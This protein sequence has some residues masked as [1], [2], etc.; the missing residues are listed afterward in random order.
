MNENLYQEKQ[1]KNRETNDIIV[2]GAPFTLFYNPHH[3]H[4]NFIFF[5]LL[6]EICMKMDVFIIYLFIFLVNFFKQFFMVF[7][8]NWST[9]A[10]KGMGVGYVLVLIVFLTF[11][12]RKFWVA[13][14]YQLG[15]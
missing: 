13:S 3:L 15:Q 12:S 4:P 5:S 8:L 14:C 10:P 11:D 1:K 6:V 2:S 9:G 7:F